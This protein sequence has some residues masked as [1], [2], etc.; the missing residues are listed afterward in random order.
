MSDTFT[1]EFPAEVSDSELE[2]IQA[3]L[4]EMSEVEDAGSM[5]AR[6]IDAQ[7]LMLW[8]QIATS[9]VGLVSA[10]VPLVQRV[11]EMIRGKGLKGVKLMLSDGT[12]FS[13]DEISAQELE[14]VLKASKT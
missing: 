12:S 2:S 5:N 6:S 13:A 8:V 4:R 11:V 3:Q 7:S 9:A 14:K 10:G 1:I